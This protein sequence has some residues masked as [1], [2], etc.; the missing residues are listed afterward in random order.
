MK[1]Q[2]GNSTSDWDIACKTLKLIRM[3]FLDARTALQQHGTTTFSR[4]WHTQNNSW[5]RVE[6]RHTS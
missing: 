6:T 5:T 1:T 2:A 4:H 3:Y